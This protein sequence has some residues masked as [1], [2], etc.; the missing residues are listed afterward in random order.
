M[1]C[2]YPISFDE[3]L[4]IEGTVD[5][6]V[7]FCYNDSINYERE[8]MVVLPKQYVE[9]RYSGYFWNTEDHHLYSIKCSGELRPMKFN[10]GGYFNHIHFQPGYTVSVNG[11]SKRV[12]LE[13][14]ETLKPTSMKQ[15]IKEHKYDQV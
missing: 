12:S 13:Y 9:T 7:P 4:N 14:L 6:T 3:T 2:A 1:E 10:K 15:V 5:K 8:A 11:V